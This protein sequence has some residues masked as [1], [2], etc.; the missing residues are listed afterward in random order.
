MLEGGIM[1]YKSVGINIFT[2]WAGLWGNKKGR[3]N[4]WFKFGNRVDC[5]MI[6]VSIVLVYG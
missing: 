3:K 5:S 4:N 1:D 2:N 6:C